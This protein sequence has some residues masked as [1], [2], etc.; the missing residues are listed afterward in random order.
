M[1]VTVGNTKGGVGKT[2][3][4]VQIALSRALAGRDVWLIDGD[5]QGTSQTA[6]AIRAEAGRKPGVACS[7]Y[8]DGPVL[9]AQVQQQGRK[10]DDIVIDAGGR[11]STALR[12][13]LV[14]SDVLLIPF[15]PRSVDVWALADI[16]ALVEE[17][18]SLRDGLRAYAVLNCA[19]PGTAS[20]D[21][22]D[23]D[24]A[25]ALADHPQLAHLD[26]PIRRRK[27]F[28]NAVGQGLSVEEIAPRD[29][30][31]CDELTALVRTLFKMRD[32]AFLRS[33]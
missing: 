22:A 10:F 14:L 33:G 16:S 27:A 17:A 30:K 7:Q 26:T 11:D 32:T 13:A 23:A 12:A 21:N 18:R 8:A 19:D 15:Q 20:S 3:L 6:V 2:V 4:A 28:A 9:R 29:P 31:A 24:A 25:A 5:R 1:V